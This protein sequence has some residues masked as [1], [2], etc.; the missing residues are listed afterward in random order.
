M[1]TDTSTGTVQLDDQYHLTYEGI[2]EPPTG[3]RHSLRY[4][5]PGMIVS[6]AIVGSG[7]LITTTTLGAQ[8]GF[9][10]LWFVIIST[11]VKVGMQVELARWSISTGQPALSG[12]NKVPPKLGQIGWVNVIWLLYFIAKNIQ[13]GGIIGGVAIGL[14]LLVPVGGNPLGFTSLLFWTIV[15]VAASIALLYSNRYSRIERG[16]SLMVVLFVVFTVAIAAGLPFTPFAYETDEVLSGLTLQ[17]PAGAV[18]AAVALFG[19]TGLSVTEITW[20]SYWCVEKG[21]A[22]WA[23]PP[24]GSDEWVRRANGWIKV[25]YKDAFV[26]FLV[27]T[28]GTLAFFVMGAAVLHPQGLVPQGNEMLTILSRMYTDTLGQWAAVAFLI[29]AVVVLGSTLWAGLP[30]YARNYTNLMSSAGLIDWQNPTARQRWIR[31][32][33]VILPIIWGAVYLFVSAP[34]LMI[35]IGGIAS[36]VVLLAVVV[37]IWY[38]RQTETDPRLH[39]SR[40]FNI[41]LIISTIAL[42]LVAVY[43]VLEVFGVSI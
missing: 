16:A 10:L 13:Y 21:Y 11:L 15:V 1:A 9:V 39:G 33:T 35:Q 29:G 20:Y 4:L 27:Y 32:W 28:F 17:I 18:G 31:I 25:M 34:V 43:T 37:A 8:A 12:Y 7:E 38:L 30:G 36:S 3:L 2:K 23:G 14:S 19:L 24:D 6:A 40:L 26:S 5:G 22:R 42:G 41:F